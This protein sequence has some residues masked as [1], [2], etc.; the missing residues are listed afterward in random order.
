MFFKGGVIWFIGL[1]D[2]V[3]GKS[4]YNAVAMWSRYKIRWLGPH[5]SSGGDEKSPMR[6]YTGSGRSGAIECGRQG[7]WMFHK[8]WTATWTFHLK[9]HMVSLSAILLC[10]RIT[11]LWFCN[12]YF[13]VIK[14]GCYLCWTWYFKSRGTGC[15]IWEKKESRIIP[16]FFPKQLGKRLYHVLQTELCFPHSSHVEILNPNMIAF[17]D[18]ALGW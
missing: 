9:C 2:H 8:R 16:S 15:G 3:G 14:K 4:S 6:R 11:C 12:K 18:R 7:T 5:C 13:Y 1:K 17:G 10:Y